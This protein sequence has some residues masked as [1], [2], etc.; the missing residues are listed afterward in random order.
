M[1]IAV[2]VASHEGENAALGESF[3][4]SDYF[5]IVEL[6]DRGIEFIE[7]PARQDGSGAGIKAVQAVAD[8][9]VEAV[10]VPRLGPKAVRALKDAGITAFEFTGDTLESAIAAFQ[11]GQLS[12]FSPE[13]CGHQH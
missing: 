9:G 3:G 2:P 4:R 11:T 7:N 12:E 8:A 13:G 10:V 5:A 1:K 6:D